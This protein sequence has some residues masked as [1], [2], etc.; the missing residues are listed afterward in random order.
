[1]ETSQL[2]L[3][4]LKRSSAPMSAGEIAEKSGIERKEVDKAMKLLKDDGKIISPRRCYWTIG[5][6]PY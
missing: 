3:D 1:M 4:I 6:E 2:I 5:K